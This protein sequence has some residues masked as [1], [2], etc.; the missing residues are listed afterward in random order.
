MKNNYDY[1]SKTQSDPLYVPT[2]ITSTY[3]EA[4][5]NKLT[6]NLV[7]VMFVIGIAAIIV[8]MVS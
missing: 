8:K 6:R 4:D 2:V 1:D 7:I 5:S 3:T